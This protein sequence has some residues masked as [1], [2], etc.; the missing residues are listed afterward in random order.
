M[1]QTLRIG[2]IM[3][4]DLDMRS[5]DKKL[6]IE[7]CI[8][9]YAEKLNIKNRNFILLVKT[10]KNLRKDEGLNGYVGTVRK[11]CIV[12]KSKK[13]Y[14]MGLDSRIKTEDLVETI[15]HEMIHVK[16]K[17]LGQL[18][19]EGRTTYWLGKKVI[20]SK[21]NYFDQPWEQEAWSKQK[22]LAVQIFKILGKLEK[23]YVM[24]NYKEK[25][26]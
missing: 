25:K 26:K 18:R 13:A 24:K 22:L 21:I 15:A 10:V 7:S 8:N 9:F 3:D 4:L 19:Y 12:D 2:G 16:Q 23:K 1:E 6:L 17:V 14:A 5:S 20:C 11:D